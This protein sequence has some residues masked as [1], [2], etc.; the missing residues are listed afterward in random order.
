M[1]VGH[2]SVWSDMGD[3]LLLGLTPEEIEDAER[4]CREFLT[5]DLIEYVDGLSDFDRRYY[6]AY[7][8]KRLKVEHDKRTI[9]MF[10]TVIQKLVPQKDED[11][12][13]P[14][15][16]KESEKSISAHEWF[17]KSLVQRQFGD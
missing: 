6:F 17:G 12:M 2:V 13:S 9:G 4:K 8:H 15:P 3:N 11:E 16:F 1:T 14:T 5:P 10:E 7:L